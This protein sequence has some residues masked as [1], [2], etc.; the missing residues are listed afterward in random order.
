M[1]PLH[2]FF[3]SSVLATITYFFTRNSD[4]HGLVKVMLVWDVFS[5]SYIITCWIIIVNR[6]A[7][8][9]RRVAKQED[10]SKYFVF[11]LILLTSFA[12]MC[13]VL[14]LISSKDAIKTSEA[15]Y[16]PIA[17]A[18]M[19]L[20]WFMVHTI[21]VFHYA[22]LYYTDAKD[23]S[24]KYAGGVTFP[25]DKSP[26]YLDFSYFSFVIGMTFQVSDVEI[27]A[28]NIRRL[29]LL[30]GLLSFGLNTFVV[31]LTINVIAGLKN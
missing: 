17:I 6:S 3:I 13:T 15:L 1:R 5:L 16:L 21:F 2:R 8:D 7:N 26:D 28:K 24:K 27:S 25:D 4:L 29:A 18:A 20:S 10:G 22:H 23:D 31:A 12:S 14:I 11:L 30:H 19:M 9:I